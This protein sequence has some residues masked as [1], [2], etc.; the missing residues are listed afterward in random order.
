MRTFE[1]RPAVRERVPLLIGLMGP[2]GGG[3]TY[4][5]M[6]L[7]TGIQKVAGGDIFVIDTE[8]RRALHYADKFRFR[9]V[10]FAPPFGPLE[11]LAAI[12][13]CV[14][15][16]AGTIIVDSM[17]HE[18]EGQGGVLEMHEL[19]TKRIA[20]AWKTTEGK[21]SMAGWAKP[22]QERRRL[23]NTILQLPA[24]FIFCFRAKNKIKV[25]AGKDP[26]PMGFM[27][28]AGEEFVYE[29]GVCALLLPG[30]GGIPTWDSNELGERQ[31]I[32]LPEWAQQMMREERPLDERAGEALARWSAGTATRTIE[33]II[34]AY[35]VC[36]DPATLGTLETERRALWKGASADEKQG[37]KLASDRATERVKAATADPVEEQGGELDGDPKAEPGEPLIA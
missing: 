14:A 28:I 13:H 36:S 15:R 25:E 12:E 8:A 35:G 31:M 33:E 17:S 2:S 22:K 29:M 18:H 5:A 30:A 27:P 4:S 1:D 37:L 26:K 16:G 10:V 19:E 9:H 24:N 34:A 6:R 20:K 21:A 23:I 11:Y 7:A 3:K 32:K